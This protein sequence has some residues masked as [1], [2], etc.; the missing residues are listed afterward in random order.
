VAVGNIRRPKN[1]PLLLQAF[2]LIHAREP[3]A[4][5][6]IVGQEDTEGLYE[7]LLAQARQLGIAEHVTFHGFV[8][9]PDTILASA[10]CFVLASSQEGFSLATIEAMLSGVPVV[11]TRCGGP[12]EIVQHD[13]TG[14]LVPVN[15]AHALS[16][17]VLD[18]F[19]Q[20]ERGQT[21][22]ERAFADATGRFNVAEM[23][24][25]YERLYQS[26]TAQLANG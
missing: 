8:A 2:S 10:D 25:Q 3:R 11:A 22:R 23:C 7:S 19:S 6:S 17:A 13:V 12:E 4:R 26:L 16:A 20:P 9:N 21:L 14:L 5:L 1:Y 24:R 18:L 15:D